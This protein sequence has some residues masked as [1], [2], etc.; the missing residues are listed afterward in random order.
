MRIIPRTIYSV[1]A[2]GLATLC[3]AQTAT[4]ATHILAA[5]DVPATT[6]PEVGASEPAESTPATDA[7]E[8]DFQRF[9]ALPV[10]GYS[11]ETE[12][13]F[14]AMGII[15]LKPNF[16]GGKV[17]ELDLTV[18][19]TTRKQIVALIS[20]SFFAFHDQLYGYVDFYYEKWV[21]H[22]FGFGNNPDMDIYRVNDSKNYY[23]M[24][25][26]RSSLFLPAALKNFKYGLDY[27]FKYST[28]DFDK[29]NADDKA[30]SIEL[31]ENADGW[32]NGLGYNLAYDT[33]DNEN[34]ARHGY[35]IRWDNIFYTKMLGDY[36]Y[37][38]Q[39]LDMRGYSEFIWNTSMAVGLLWQRVDGNAPFDKL[40]GPDGTKRFRGV[41]S[42]FF[43]GH[44]ALFLQTEFRKE[45]FWRLA[46]TIFFE[47]GKA[48]EYFSDLMRNE[49]HRSV[50]FGGQFAL[51]KS[52]RLF[53]RGDFSWVDF[54]SLG[55]TVYIREAF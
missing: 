48:G 42:N 38:T 25:D 4:D 13:Q 1:A 32:R 46:G 8:N 44:Q 5:T 23:A 35:L 16:K 34:W 43:N 39:S 52:E 37:T 9:T 20:P 45:L 10:L 47:G 51:N 49:W 27:E 11:E 6:A 14:G 24:G 22:F 40:A 3:A 19:G 12:L 33:R 18:Y 21:N 29:V 7:P 41:E 31:P 36:S 15:F 54:K 2:F 26:M 28:F 50:G 30:A 53:A 17:A 55:L